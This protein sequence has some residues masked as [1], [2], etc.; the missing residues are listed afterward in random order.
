MAADPVEDELKT[1]TEV[2]KAL[3]WAGFDVSASPPLA[4]L[5]GMSVGG[6]YRIYVRR[7]QGEGSI[8]SSLSHKHCC[9]SYLDTKRT[10]VQNQIELSDQSN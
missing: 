9:T 1:L 8:I 2:G 4:V 6:R 10:R 5:Q 3:A 7:A